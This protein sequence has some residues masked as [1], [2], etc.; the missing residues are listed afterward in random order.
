M[1]DQFG[2]RVEYLRVSVTDKCNLRC[3]YCMPLEGLTWLKRDELLDYEEIETV[4]RTMAGMGLRRVRITGGEPLIRR[5]LPDLIR[6][7]SAIREIE[8]LSLSTNAVLLA[9]QAQELKDA[10]IQRLNISLDSLQQERVDEIARRPGSFHKIFEG[11]EAAER[12]GFTPIKVNVVLI[13]DRNDDEI[14]DFARITKE[15]PW[16][17]R[18]I[19]VMPTGSNLDLSANSFVSCQEALRRV[20]A[21]DKLEPVDGPFGNGPADYYRFPG[22][23][24]TVGV[25]TPMSHNYC[26]RCNRMR[27]TAAGQLRP[28]LF[29][30]IETNLRDPL[31]AGQDLRPLIEET[32]QIKPE[33]HYLVQGSDVGSGGL[34]ALSQTGG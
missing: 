16:H 19:E 18:F 6:K 13:R 15:R 23:P 28:C 8:D 4:I 34:V 21:M 22:A 10:G 27:L 14:E 32:L 31:R 33:R 20:R 25:I 12:V 17:V 26:H 1:I 30:E 9:D 7:I 2:R 24:G 29:G 5:D 3:I 11:L